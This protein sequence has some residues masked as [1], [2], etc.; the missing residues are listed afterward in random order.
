M[1]KVRADRFV[2]DNTQLHRTRQGRRP[3]CAQRPRCYV[4]PSPYIDP[5]ITARHPTPPSSLH[6]CLPP[7][8]C[9]ITCTAHLHSLSPVPS[10]PRLGSLTALTC[11]LACPFHGAALMA[12][13]L[14]QS[15]PEPAHDRYDLLLAR[16][17]PVTPRH[18]PHA[19]PTSAH[20]TQL[21]ARPTPRPVSRLLH[22]SLRSALPRPMVHAPPRTHSH[23]V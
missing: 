20:N 9:A 23:V 2:I 7:F 22:H 19:A 16:L 10:P 17:S 15:R 3:S 21:A 18:T 12:S 8:P 5:S 14:G 13:G 1:E 4:S 11:A 6:L